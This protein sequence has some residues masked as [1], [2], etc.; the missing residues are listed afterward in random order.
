MHLGRSTDYSATCSRI[1]GQ[2]CNVFLARFLATC[3]GAREYN[4]QSPG[5]E[6]YRV[7]YYPDREDN[8]Y[9]LFT[10]RNPKCRDSILGTLSYYSNIPLKRLFDDQGVRINRNSEVVLVLF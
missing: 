6:K 5:T 1:V 8:V 10:I 9:L 7:Q 3:F 2:I 4:A